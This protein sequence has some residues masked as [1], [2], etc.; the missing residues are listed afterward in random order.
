MSLS[1]CWVDAAV[2]PSCSEGAGRRLKKY[3][4]NPAIRR[5]LNGLLTK[6]GATGPS[7]AAVFDFDDTCIF[8]D[9]GRAVFLHQ[10]KEFYF[11]LPPDTFAQVLLTG[12]QTI[13]GQPTGEI[14][15]ELLIVYRQLWEIFS[16]NTRAGAEGRSPQHERFITLFLWYVHE[17]RREK[18]LGAAYVFPLLAR[19]M[20]G[21]S[22]DEVREFTR[23]VL[24]EVVDEPIACHT[25]SA[26]FNGIP[27]GIEVQHTTGLRIFAE[28]VDLM[29]CLTRSG[30]P[31]YVISASNQWVVQAAA[32][33]L[34]FPVARE[35]IF[36]I[37]VELDP[38]QFLLTTVPPDYP[39]TYRA[40]KKWIID[41]LIEEEPVLVA[42]DAE[43]DYEMLTMADV[44]FRLV[45]N[46]GR[47][48]LISALY[49][50]P[51]Y[52]VQKIDRRLGCFQARSFSS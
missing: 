31:C 52:L 29:H 15:T 33:L 2:P 11:R 16:Q 32:H 5:T 6:A 21:Y 25:R 39:V 43:T 19:I 20:A 8:R 24:R 4:W 22:V 38:E 27:G 37:R 12:V 48:G 35:N 51:K 23:Q 14:L 17:A 3:N 7:K 30:T 42:G 26:D 41:N 46:H 40:G 1:N 34:G 28:M 18:E 50:N 45:L 10:L 49:T 13:G 36:G 47:T 9:V 44:P